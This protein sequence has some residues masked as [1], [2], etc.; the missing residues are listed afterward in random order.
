PDADGTPILW[1]GSNGHG[2]IR[3]DV[4]DPERPRLVSEPE[5]PVLPIPK[6]Y[7]AVRDG[8]GDILVCTDYGVF[9]WR[10][11]GERY[12]A[13]AYHREDGG[14]HAEGNG[15]ALDVGARG[16][17]WIGTVGGAAVYTPPDATPRRPS[18]LQLTGLRVDGQPARPIRG[19][20]ALPRADSTLEL[21]YDLL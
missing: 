20:L 18:P 3:I 1:M 15:K 19:A 9:S 6:A 12:Q 11:A 4:R 7:G 5:L 13:T 14:P 8:R 16:R 2:L 21:H 17:V 10:L